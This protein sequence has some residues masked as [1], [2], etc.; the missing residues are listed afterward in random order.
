MNALKWNKMPPVLSPCVDVNGSFMERDEAVEKHKMSYCQV[1][2]A[3]GAKCFWARDDKFATNLD[4]HLKS[5]KC[6]ESR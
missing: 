6:V 4:Y 1:T 2:L 3:N 5:H